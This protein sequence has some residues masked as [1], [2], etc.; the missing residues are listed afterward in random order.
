MSALPHL[1]KRQRRAVRTTGS[2]NEARQMPGFAVMGFVK[3][4]SAFFAPGSHNG[5]K[6]CGWRF[7]SKDKIPGQRTGSLRWM[8]RSW[9]AAGHITGLPSLC[10][11][12][13][14]WSIDGKAGGPAYAHGSGNA[15]ARWPAAGHVTCATAPSLK[16]VI[17]GG[18]AA[19]WPAAGH[20][21]CSKGIHR[22]PTLRCLMSSGDPKESCQSGDWQRWTHTVRWPAAGHGLH[23]LAH[24]KTSSTAAPVA[25]AVATPL[26]AINATR[27]AWWPA[28]GHGKT[29]SP[30]EVRSWR[31]RTKCRGA[32]PNDPVTGPPRATHRTSESLVL[33]VHARVS[34]IFATTA[35]P[36]PRVARSGPPSLH[37]AKHEDHAMT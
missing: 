22:T 1:D 28:A 19:A 7:Y 4:G 20:H 6:K 36:S 11:P 30:P 14:S 35:D 33:S 5:R 3:I 13:V 27:T 24:D 21:D 10:R 9:P 32:T 31:S 18:E 34:G 29:E 12:I 37:L 15:C 17:L 26:L 8:T 16:P 25:S 23:W 2:T